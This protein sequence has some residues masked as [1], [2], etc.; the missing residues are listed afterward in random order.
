MNTLRST[1]P[2]FVR[3]IKPNLQQVAKKFDSIL[4]L[5]QLKYS[6]LFEAIRI[7]K[8]G[9]EIRV[10]HDV[11]IR[12]YQHVLVVPIT[13]KI[14]LQQNIMEYCNQL[15]QFMMNYIEET[16]SLKDKKRNLEKVAFKGMKNS[17]ANITS[18][19]TPT[20]REY[21][22]GKTK[23]FLRNQLLKVLFND[24]SELTRGNVLVPIQSM[25][26]GFLIRRRFKHLLTQISPEIKAQQREQEANERILMSNEDEL[27]LELEMIF[28]NDKTLQRRIYEARQQKIR[29]EREKV[30]RKHDMA[31]IRIQ[32]HWKGYMIR[33]KYRVIMCEQLLEKAIMKR[34]DEQLLQRA[35]SQ[36][37]KWKVSSKL[38]TYYTKEVKKLI[39][40]VMEE[41][42]VDNE[43]RNAILLRSYPLLKQAIVLAEEHKMQTYLNSYQI[44][45]QTLQSLQQNRIILQLVNEY[46]HKSSTIPLLLSHYYDILTY[47]VTQ[48]ITVYHLQGEPAISQ[49]IHRL[50]QTHHLFL[51]RERLRTAIEICSPLQMREAYLSRNKYVKFFGEEFLSE[52]VIAMENMLH[53][54]SY[55]QSLLSST[56]D[57]ADELQSLNPPQSRN[58]NSNSSNSSNRNNN[59]TGVKD[60]Y[61]EHL[62]KFIGKKLNMHEILYVVLRSKDFQDVPTF[63]N[64]HTNPLTSKAN[65]IPKSSIW[66]DGEHFNLE[67]HPSDVRIYLPKFIRDPLQ[68]MRDATTTQEYQQALREYVAVVPSPFERRFYLRIFKWTT[69]FSTWRMGLQQLLQQVQSQLSPLPT[70]PD[71]D[72]LQR[73]TMSGTSASEKILASSSSSSS[74][75]K[76]TFE[77]DQIGGKT[78]SDPFLKSSPTKTGTNIPFTQR[79]SKSTVAAREMLKKG[80]KVCNASII[81]FFSKVLLLILSTKLQ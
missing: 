77:E 59:M 19:N 32:K 20:K 33:C 39:L 10:N 73:S 4:A 74:P 40:Q 64:H 36:P 60:K 31:V 27:A 81:S 12:R 41:N 7:R 35:M 5:N 67:D 65:G 72:T 57:I 15:I 2:H 38:I 70:L 76:V 51:L 26:R 61:E 3:C 25:I 49:A 62:S 23:V 52:E 11:F 63:L 54:L 24:V 48:A 45:Q 80:Q 56:Y 53:M 34:H 21:Y 6:G 16:S 13:H 29:E 50:K 22:V 9:Y 47:L 75:M 1:N 78:S 37:M 8:S 71:L 58:S 18:T 43:L 55:Q 66:D 42:Y 46:L 44:A 28:R 17:L 69:A 79:Q 30:K 68:V 14:V